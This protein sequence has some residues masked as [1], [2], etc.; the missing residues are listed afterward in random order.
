MLSRFIFDG[1][2]EDSLNNATWPFFSMLACLLVRSD[3]P[4][5]N[6][7]SSLAAVHPVLLVH[8]V[9]GLEPGPYMLVRDPG[10]LPPLT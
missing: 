7:L 2:Y 9:D 4:P 6:A 8:R 1:T 10:A 3:T 5:W